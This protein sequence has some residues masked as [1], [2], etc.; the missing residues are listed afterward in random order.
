MSF[1]ALSLP[2]PV[3]S[4]TLF[5]ND[6]ALNVVEWGRGP[7]APSSPL[8]DEA[9][10][11]LNAYFDGK[12]EAFDLPLDPGGTDFQRAVWREMVRIPYGQIRTYGDLSAV[13]S[14]SPRAVGGACGANP[15]PI[16]VP[17]HRVVG[18][19]GKMTGFSG[20]AGVETKVQLLTLEGAPLPAPERPE[21]DLFD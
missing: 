10:A 21:P 7:E 4:L 17:C 2:S 12:L 5:A 16:I 1:F 20:G 3:G 11:Q 18:A 15:I 19:N 8:L 14:S 6:D 13:L 9:A